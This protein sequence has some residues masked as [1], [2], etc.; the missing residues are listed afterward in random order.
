MNA[1]T[2]ASTPPRAFSLRK[3][4]S[5]QSSRQTS[6]PR[7]SDLSAKAKATL[8]TTQRAVSLSKGSSAHSSRQLSLPRRYRVQAP[9][10]AYAQPG[11][12][13]QPASAGPAVRS[14]DFLV[15]GSGIA[16]LSYALKVAQYGSV[17][18]VS[19][20]LTTCVLVTPSSDCAPVTKGC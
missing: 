2:L 11:D 8:T 6:L 9:A 16:G 5:S 19:Y 7:R 15:L 12:A 10:K 14:Y 20:W 1:C 3:Q 17:A 4:G 18:V 13:A